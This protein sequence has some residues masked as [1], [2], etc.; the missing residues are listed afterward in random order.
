MALR[1][2]SLRNLEGLS[3]ERLAHRVSHSGAVPGMDP[4]TQPVCG[5]DVVKTRLP[6]QQRGGGRICT[7]CE[8]PGELFLCVPKYINTSALF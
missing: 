5:S 4:A 3:W 2:L 7:C 8:H 1:A 6:T